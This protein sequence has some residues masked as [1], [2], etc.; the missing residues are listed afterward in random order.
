MRDPKDLPR[1]IA[2]GLIAPSLDGGRMAAQLRLGHRTLEVETR[3]GQRF[4]LPLDELEVEQGGAS[5]RMVMLHQNSSRITAFSE[6]GRLLTMLGSQGTPKIQARVRQLIAA[7]R[8]RRRRRRTWLLGSLTVLVLLI[9]GLKLSA[10]ALGSWLLGAV[11]HEVD[12]KLGEVG[13][14]QMRGGLRIVHKDKTEK[15]LDVMLRRLKKG[16]L[17]QRWQYE[18]VLVEDK[19]VNA[20]ALPGGRMVFFTGLIEKA[21]RPEEVAAVM[22]HELAHVT[23][24]HGTRR[25]V[26]S[27]G[28][29]G[30][31][32]VLLGDVGGIIGLAKELLALSAINSYSRDQEAEADTEAVEL[33]RQAHLDPMAL[34]TFFRRL[35][36]E[37]GDVPD[38]L[39]WMSTHPSHEARVRAVRR[40]LKGRE[41]T[42]RP[43]SM[44]WKAVQAELR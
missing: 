5:G 13:W 31:L 33:L 10:G 25:V 6:D 26:Q 18:L 17:S 32:Q 41:V 30:A 11:P 20:F 9:V 21:K 15:A 4:S 39:E 37:G 35:E 27:V 24:R 8:Q 22:A 28:I 44:D 7:T 3:D 29:I 34:A 16:G 40:Q 1:D 14:T 19:R 38:Y 42:P 36:K 23:E 2:G 43:L 12:E